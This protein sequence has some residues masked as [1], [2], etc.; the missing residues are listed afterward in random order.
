MASKD[1][2]LRLALYFPNVPDQSS[3]A[4][5]LLSCFGSIFFASLS[6]GR[7]VDTTGCSFKDFIKGKLPML[8]GVKATMFDWEQVWTFCL[9]LFT[10]EG[11]GFAAPP[12]LANFPFATPSLPSEQHLTTIFP[13]VRLKRFL[14][15][16]YLC[17]VLLMGC[18]E[19]ALI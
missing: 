14:E 8:P 9:S 17:A 10:L 18:S 2:A 13:E 11:V 16:K 3:I 12:S 6:Q 5:F 4:L 1:S 7:Y 15:V 19:L